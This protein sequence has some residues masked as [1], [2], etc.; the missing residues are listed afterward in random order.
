MAGPGLLGSL[1]RSWVG[2]V[3][4]RDCG[5][6][7]FLGDLSGGVKLVSDR[8]SEVCLELVDGDHV[9][10]VPGHPL[11]D[12]GADLAADAL[13]PPDPDRGNDRP[14]VTR[15]RFMIDAIHRAEGDAG[16]TSGA[17][18]IDD[19]H[20]ARPF[21]LLG[22]LVVMGNILVHGAL[23]LLDMAPVQF[24][25]TCY[26]GPSVP[27]KGGDQH[28]ALPVIWCYVEIPYASVHQ[29]KAMA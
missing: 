18:V 25:S 9:D 24:G 4:V 22:L 11:A 19:G 5:A 7:G 26:H 16:L 2:A 8:D 3:L 17:G 28:L 27:V 20:E 29:H 14:G 23:P 12:P 6:H 15:G 21:L 13:V 1:A 10:G